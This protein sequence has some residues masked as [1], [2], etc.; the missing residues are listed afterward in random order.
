MGTL[1]RVLLRVLLGL[2]IFASVLAI[3]YAVL[4][5]GPRDPM[6]FD[7]PT[8][9]PRRPVYA[10]SFAA[11][12]GSPWATDV[13]VRMLERGGNAFDAAVASLLMLNVTNGEAA[14]FPGIAPTLAYDAR[15]GT[16]SSYIGAGVAPAAATIERFVAAGHD[17][18]P[19]FSILGQLVPASPD[20]MIR[21]LADYGTMSFRDVADPAIGAARTGFPVS[22]TMQK[23]LDLSL[24]ER[25]GFRIMLP[26]NAQVYFKGQWWRAI[27][28]GDRFTRPELAATW[29]RMADV[30]RATIEAGG[31]RA[32]AL[33]AVRTCF[34]EGP[35][36]EAILDLHER[37]KGL[38]AA[39]D[40]SS[41]QGA[42]EEPYEA[43][44]AA[45]HGRYRIFTNTGWTQGIVVPMAMKILEGI[46]LASFGHN[47]PY[48][49]HTVV[50][51]LD[52]ALADREAYVGDPSF[53][54]VPAQTLMSDRYATVRR[55]AMIHGSFGG[56][57]APGAIAGYQPYVP[58][59]AIPDRSLQ[60][61]SDTTQLVVADAQGNVVAI[62][63]SDFPKSPMVPG[64]GMTL[65]DRMVQFR[66]DPASPT[67]LE[68][69]KRPRVTPHAVMVF[70]DGEF[71]L[72]F[73]TPGGDVQ[74]QTLVQVLLNL[75]VFDME[76]QEA[77]SAPR[78]RSMSVPSSFSPHGAEPSVLWVESPL[79][80]A[81][82]V[83]L[84]AL[85]Y[86]VEERE[87]W[88]NEFGAVGAIIGDGGRWVAA[89]DPREST[90]AAGK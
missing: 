28:R 18:V 71:W 3:V 84:A 47:S 41:Y 31:S 23:N 7:D 73:N 76:L 8:G 74:A 32:E 9:E 30:E 44:Y 57:P 46:D 13:A 69:G 89:A 50:Q 87:K 88:D 66:L 15:R 42:W 11:V 85:G 53:V 26:Y 77:I 58:P 81:T 38:F 6:T 17:V 20:V 45:A 63:P 68:P 22:A 80:A 21:L 65:G 37:E 56:L 36:A 54:D 39:S 86:Q 62:T 27:H 67:S 35:L 72:A 75:V 64:T 19:D 52:L 60:V 34:Y 51:A 2:V 12:T 14:S 25:I 49:V 43:S 61:G 55:R 40:L 48:Y 10:R 59:E 29:E 78:F 79:Y 16:V 33:R 83:E 70:R 1:L 24:I 82:G 4:P 90:W 5:K